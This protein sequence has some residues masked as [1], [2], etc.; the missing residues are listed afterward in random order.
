[1]WA[2]IHTEFLLTTEVPAQAW[3]L[4]SSGFGI[5]SQGWKKMLKSDSSKTPDRIQPANS[6]DSTKAPDDSDSA[7]TATTAPN[8]PNDADHNS[9]EAE[10]RDKMGSALLLSTAAW[11]GLFLGGRWF[12]NCF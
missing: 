5:R 6:S 12:I 2:E 1:M 9:W 7:Q 4:M 10:Y 8:A 11:G 3:H